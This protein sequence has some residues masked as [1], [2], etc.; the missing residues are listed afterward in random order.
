V[1]TS[2]ASVDEIFQLRPLAREQKLRPR[3]IKTGLIELARK[4][5]QLD[6]PLAQGFDMLIAHGGRVSR[7]TFF[8]W[9][10]ATPFSAARRH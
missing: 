6:N 3:I 4:P 7:P 9:P 1:L 5:V 2:A 10:V 8:G